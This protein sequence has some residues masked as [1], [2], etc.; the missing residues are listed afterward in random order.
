M[1]V[2]SDIKQ[3]RTELD[4]QDDVEAIVSF[5]LDNLG[6]APPPPSFFQNLADKSLSTPTIDSLQARLQSEKDQHRKEL[7]KIYDFQMAEREKL[8][9][10]YRANMDEGDYAPDYTIGDR[11]KGSLSEKERPALPLPPQTWATASSIQQQTY[12]FDATLNAFETAFI[13]SQGPIYAQLEA[14][15][16]QEEERRNASIPRS[17]EE[18]NAITSKSHQIA[19]ARFLDTGRAQLLPQE[20][21]RR[22]ESGTIDTTEALKA[23][24]VAYK[25]EFAFQTR[26]KELLASIQSSDPRKRAQA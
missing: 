9:R 22:I 19:I 7:S 23:L 4:D 17:L 6:T 13:S 3:L 18:F 1:S 2:R 26:V 5:M 8:Y 25:S 16:K 24:T 20:V 11:P 21:Q 15:K 12:T 10:M 14:L